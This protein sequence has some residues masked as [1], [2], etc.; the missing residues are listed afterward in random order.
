M[1][2]AIATVL[3]VGILFAMASVPAMAGGGKV[4]GAN[5]QGGINQVQIQDPP[6]FQP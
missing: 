1:R 5:G 4:R 3:I 6:P 2:K